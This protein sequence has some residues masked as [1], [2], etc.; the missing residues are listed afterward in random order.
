MDIRQASVQIPA[1]PLHL[2]LRC[3]LSE[4][5]RLCELLQHLKNGHKIQCYGVVVATDGLYLVAKN[6]RREVK[7][8]FASYNGLGQMVLGS[9]FT[10][11]KWVYAC[12]LP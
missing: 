12:C 5:L 3:S 1:S 2:M 6:E 10:S 4:P 7:L 8:C 11:V 9:T